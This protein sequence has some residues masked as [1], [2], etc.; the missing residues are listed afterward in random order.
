M[1]GNISCFLKKN[2][3]LVFP[4]VPNP[5]EMKENL[6]FI[7]TLILALNSLC[8]SAEAQEKIRF[9]QILIEDLQMVQYETDTTAPAVILYD[10]G[11]F[12]G[13]TNVFYTTR[14]T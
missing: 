5:T 7:S 9:G 14:S 8:F 3:I 10:K 2:F 1:D 12:N 11:H 4:E 6:P 13:N